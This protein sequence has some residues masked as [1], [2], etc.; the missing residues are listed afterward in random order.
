MPRVSEGE[1]Q[2]FAERCE[3]EVAITLGVGLA[4]PTQTRCLAW[5]R[6]ELGLRAALSATLEAPRRLAQG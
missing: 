1:T 6:V 4:A 3:A 2:T 5:G